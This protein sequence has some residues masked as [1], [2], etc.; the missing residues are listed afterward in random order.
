MFLR[1]PS[2]RTRQR[3]GAC[4]GL[5]ALATI[6]LFGGGD[7]MGSSDSFSPRGIFG[8]YHDEAKANAANIRRISDFQDVLTEFFTEFSPDTDG[9]F[10]LVKKELAA[11]NAI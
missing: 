5:A 1:P 2:K 9:K 3:R 8:G 7:A 4:V 10:F 6:G 11:L